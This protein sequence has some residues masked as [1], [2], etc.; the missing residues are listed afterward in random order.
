MVKVWATS[1]VKRTPF[2]A[3]DLDRWFLGKKFVFVGGEDESYFAP[4]RC[5]YRSLP[6]HLRRRLRKDA[7]NKTLSSPLFPDEKFLLDA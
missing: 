1:P 6:P 3:L 2:G 5:R 7:R 4:W